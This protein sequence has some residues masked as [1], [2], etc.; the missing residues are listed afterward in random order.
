MLKTVWFVSLGPGDPEL[1]TLKGLKAL[2]Q[3]GTI[4][5]PSTI[6]PNGKSISR[7]KDI[8]LALNIDED[9]IT[10]FEVPMN[11]DRTKALESYKE[12]SEKIATKYKDGF[13]IAVTAEGDAGFYSSSHYIGDNLERMNIPTSRI[14]GVP[15]FITCGALANLHIAKQEEELNVIPG[16]I[17]Q[18]ELTEK[19]NAGKSVVVMK[20][21]QCEEVIK[22]TIKNLPDI[23]LYYFEN[24][25]LSGKEFYTCNNSDILSRKFPYFSLLII[26]KD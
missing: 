6:A 5:C 2:Q 25:G 9:K 19:I 16:V 8:L 10:T 23:T 4:F 11:K 14:A 20:P 26:R 15:A 1:I 3:A 13:Q 22:N 12:I 21:S 24:V 7:A 18:E 17:S